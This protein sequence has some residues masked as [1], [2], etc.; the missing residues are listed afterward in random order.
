[1]QDNRRR[2]NRSSSNLPIAIKIDSQITV[3]GELKDISEKSA[4]VKLKESIYVQ[5]NDEILFTIS[6]NTQQNWIVTGQARISRIDKGE[7]FV[8]YFTVMDPES[9]ARLNELFNH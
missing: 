9:T 8:I 2:Y 6:S 4:F 5:V 7:G 3:K 1:M